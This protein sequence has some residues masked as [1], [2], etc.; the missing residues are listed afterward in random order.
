MKIT[1]TIIARGFASYVPDNPGAVDASVSA[2]GTEIGEVTL[3]P[4]KDRPG[5]CTWGPSEDF[6]ADHRT[7]R[8]LDTQD[9]RAQAI[10]EIVAAVEEVNR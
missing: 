1:A 9:E 6:W 8:W 3:I 4:R 2:D 7:R 5:L 10:A